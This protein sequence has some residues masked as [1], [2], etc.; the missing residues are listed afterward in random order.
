MSKKRKRKL[1]FRVG[2]VIGGEQDQFEDRIIISVD[3]KKHQYGLGFPDDPLKTVYR[4]TFF[5]C[6]KTYVLKPPSHIPKEQHDMYR[7][8]NGRY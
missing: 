7:R 2:D 3:R 4:W 5:Q 8:L 1:W 6:H